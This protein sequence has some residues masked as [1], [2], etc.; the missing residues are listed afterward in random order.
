MRKKLLACATAV[1]FFCNNCYVAIAQTMPMEEKIVEDNGQVLYSFYNEGEKV[2]ISSE[3]DYD[4]CGTYEKKVFENEVKSQTGIM[5]AELEVTL[6][7][8][9]V[10]DSEIEEM[11]PETV[12]NLSNA[13][14]IQI[15]SSIYEEREGELAEMKDEEREEYYKEYYNKKYKSDRQGS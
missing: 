13:T 1:L 14:E 10:L 12:E 11:S 9:G 6:N 2:V 5:D 7:K 3:F 15:M 8:A 4:D